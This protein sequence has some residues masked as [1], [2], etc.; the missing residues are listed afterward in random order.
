M[1]SADVASGPDS[2][3]VGGRRPA[4]LRLRSSASNLVGMRTRWRLLPAGWRVTVVIVAVVVLAA[5]LIKLTSVLTEGSSPGGPDSSS[6][7]PAPN[8]LA[9]FSELLTRS[10]DHVTQLTSPL[11]QAALPAGS[12]VVVAAPTSWQSADSTTLVRVLD[13][14][15]AVV[16]AGEPPAGLLSVLLAANA[17]QWSAD[18]LTSATAVGSSPLVFGASQ[19]DSTGPGSWSTTGATSPLL[20]SS[21][22]QGGYLAVSARVG[23]GTLVLLSSPSPLQN[24]LI[25]QAD[26]A[27]FAIDIADPTS[28]AAAPGAASGTGT[29]GRS[30]VFD[31]YDHGYGRAGSGI[32]GLPGSWKAALLLAFIAVLVWMLSASRRFGP[33]E[34]DSRELAPPRAAYVE[35]MATLLST[36]DPKSVASVA[37]PLSSRARI[38]LC[39]RAGVPVDASDEEIANA[40][41][42]S[43]LPGD[44]VAA[45]LR[46]PRSGEDLVAVG[47]AA[48][49]FANNRGPSVELTK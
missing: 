42:S 45:V 37:E 2:T 31:E 39:R 38:A 49:E 9:A 26:N 3:Q 13:S 30:V 10:G 43:G 40:A 20:A 28:S 44:L 36:A 41:A 27:A 16:V 8:G 15:G 25:G 47:R 48:A 35:A 1:K 4:S 33:P 19:V 21:G 34:K 24:R 17:P 32:G 29:S 46:T 12:T 18:E 14:G 22:T 5:A 7:S 23:D 11:D 6:F